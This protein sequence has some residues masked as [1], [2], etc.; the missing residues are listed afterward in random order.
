MAGNTVRI[1]ITN[2]FGGGDYTAQITVGSQNT[3]VNVILDTGSST[4][5]VKQGAYQPTSDQS[6]KATS[7]AQNVLYGTGGWAGPV[8]NTS[9]G[10][11]VAGNKVSLANAFLAVADEQQPH[12]FGPA[13]GILGLAYT[14]LN[15]AYD[16]AAYLQRQRINPAVTYPWPFPIRNSSAALAQF[17]QLLNAMPHEDIPPYFTEL[18]SNGI[19]PN[20][21]AFYTLRSS[22]RATAEDVAQD[23]L[24][25]GFFILGGGEEE[26]DL[27]EGDFL[28]VDVL[29]DVYYNTNLKAIQVDGC[30]PVNVSPLPTKFSQTMGS[31]SIVDSGTS[32]LAL[33]PAVFTAIVDSLHSLNP[34]FT[35]VI[36]QA[37]RQGV[38]SSSLDLSKWPGI[39]FV[40]TGDQDQDVTLTCSPDTYWQL[41]VSKDGLAI[42]QI[43]NIQ[44]PQSILG[45]PLLNNYFAVF[46][47]SIDSYGVIRFARINKALAT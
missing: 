11:G 34:G 45:L 20:K 21:F 29:D 25:Q 44:S 18:E 24:N 26:K 32:I 14:K 19:T 8:V 23:P 38:P 17:Q 47:R 39:S 28:N 30:D 43:A 13:D 15:R 12:N 33:S 5:A 22:P 7:Y 6:L 16:L 10:M 3:V 35:E 42:F 37:M 31:N 46:D 40:L 27:Y 2:I 4:L 9:I 36:M 1:P 41:D